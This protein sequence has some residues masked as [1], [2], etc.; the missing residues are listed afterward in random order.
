MAVVLLCR[1]SE[2]TATQRTR[3]DLAPLRDGF[4]TRERAPVVKRFPPAFR[5]NLFGPDTA[6]T[7][8]YG[9][10]RA[11][12][13][14]SPIEISLKRCSQNWALRVGHFPCPWRVA[15]SSWTRFDLAGESWC[16]RTI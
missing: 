9:L 16:R 8:G 1:S 10:T 2:H 13:H 4:N 15:R 11:L 6:S 12:P 14:P 7:R 5:Y 3:R